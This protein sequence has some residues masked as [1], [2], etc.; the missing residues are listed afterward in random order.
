MM[1]T[2]GKSYSRES[3]LHDINTRFGPNVRFYTCSAEDLTAEGLIDF[4]QAKGK[5]VPMDG[6][7]QTSPDLVCKH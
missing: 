6:G 3:L 1:L 5:F 4:L 7:F 2:S